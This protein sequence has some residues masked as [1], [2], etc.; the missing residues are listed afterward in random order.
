MNS[1]V[2]YL[3]YCKCHNV[4]PPST[5]TEK[6]NKHTKNFKKW[7]QKVGGESKVWFKQCVLK[8]TCLLS[9]KPWVQTAVPL[10][11]KK[12]REAVNE[13]LVWVKAKWWKSIHPTYIR[14]RLYKT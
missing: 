4:C 6:K 13:V 3:I 1:S 11:K 5:T 14:V 12:R 7:C 9:V 10:K 2:I 8:H